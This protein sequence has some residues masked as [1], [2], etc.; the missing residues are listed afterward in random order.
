MSL[1]SIIQAVCDRCSL[2]RPTVVTTATDITHLQLLG[3]AQQEGRELARVGT[4]R[5]LTSE[6]TFTTVAAAAQTSSVPSDFDWYI[7]DSMFNRTSRRRVAGPLSPEEWQQTQATLVT[8]VNPAFRMRGSSSSAILMS[9][10]PTAGHTVAYEYITKN[11]CQSNA[12]A[13][14][15]AWA[16]DTDTAILDE[17]LHTLGIV[18]RW[19]KAKGFDYAEE[20]TT[21][22]YQVAQALMRDGG[23]P[24]ISTDGAAMSRA[25][26]SPQVPDTY[27]FA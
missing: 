25:P 2:V 11:W 6:H 14:L 13:P 23:R 4:W 5:A 12:S 8:Y 21:Y 10:T 7:P 16:A 9:P 26:N 27:V 17:E 20:F 3:L 1:L 15:S 19:K 18:W 22:Q 24:R